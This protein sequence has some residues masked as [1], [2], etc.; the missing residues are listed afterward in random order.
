M[1]AGEEVHNLKQNLYIMVDTLKGWELKL[2]T[3]KIRYLTQYNG[4]VE[5]MREAL[6][7]PLPQGIPDRPIMMKVRWTQQW[8]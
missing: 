3:L 5:A 7:G 4:E 6:E 2:Q 1:P 8:F